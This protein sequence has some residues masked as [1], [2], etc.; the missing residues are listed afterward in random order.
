MTIFDLKYPA[1][2]ISRDFGGLPVVIRLGWI[3]L[4]YKKQLFKRMWNWQDWK[5]HQRARQKYWHTDWG[6]KRKFYEKGHQLVGWRIECRLCG[7]IFE[8]FNK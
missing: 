4:P 2:Q 8:E 3:P 1:I 7:E 5:R 6:V